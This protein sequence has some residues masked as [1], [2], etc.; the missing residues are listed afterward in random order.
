MERTFSGL[1][2]LSLHELRGKQ[3]LPGTDNLQKI[4]FTFLFSDLNKI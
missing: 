3:R 4:D 2:L 1:L